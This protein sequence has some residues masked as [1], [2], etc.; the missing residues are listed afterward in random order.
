MSTTVIAKTALIEA[1]QVFWRLTAVRECSKRIMELSKDRQKLKSE[2]AEASKLRDRIQGEGLGTK[3]NRSSKKRYVVDEE[4]FY[5]QREEDE[6]KKDGDIDEKKPVSRPG[7]QMEKAEKEPNLA[8]RLGLD[9]DQ[10]EKSKEDLEKEQKRKKNKEE[11]EKEKE[12][13]EVRKIIESG[14]N[15][16]KYI[17]DV[18]LLG[19]DIG[20][21]NNP[22]GP[23]Q[24]P[25]NQKG[26][27]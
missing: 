4:A 6:N 3:L 13:D 19:T 18:D 26:T 16:N 25:A 24:P 22:K 11:L 23:S 14:S 17:I 27:F 9:E 8:R 20:S 12:I 15:L 2:R 1:M 7:R 10:T 21:P 5:N